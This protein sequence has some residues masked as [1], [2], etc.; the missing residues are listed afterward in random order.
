MAE[1]RD[2]VRATCVGVVQQVTTGASLQFA[3]RCAQAKQCMQTE[4]QE[5]T[6]MPA[7]DN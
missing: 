2:G 4:L 6:I 5:P 7:V 3:A 1:L